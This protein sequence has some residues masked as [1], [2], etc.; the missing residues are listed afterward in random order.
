MSD[1]SYEE[2]KRELT[3]KEKKADN[4][5]R[6]KVLLIC[7]IFFLAF[8][9]YLL[10]FR[11]GDVSEISGADIKAANSSYEHIQ[12][13]YIEDLQILHAKIGSDDN[14]YCIAKFSDRDRKEWII[15]FTPGKNAEL[16]DRIRTMI[17]F[18]KPLDL[19][20][21][22]YFQMKH[23]EALPP[24]G[25]SYFSVYSESYAD[26]E[27]TNVLDLNADYLC[28]KYENFTLAEISHPS[29]PFASMILGLFGILYGGYLLIRNRKNKNEIN[30]V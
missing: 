21:S 2:Y 17:S 7:G 12:A 28:A 16:T 30:A 15:C 9:I 22:G 13:Y 26:A 8:L 23:M 3:K 25:D 6:G 24:T 29:I 1:N 20:V 14:V 18:E 19:T 5:H 11:A 4:D 27:S 10:P